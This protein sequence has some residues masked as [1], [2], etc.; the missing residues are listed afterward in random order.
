MSIK[1]LHI[2]YYDESGGAAIAVK[3]IHKALI[4]NNLN[5]KIFVAVKTSNDPNIIGPKS[6]LEEI[7]WK[8]FLSL[9]RRIQRFENKSKYDSNSYNLI[10]NNIV[11]KINNL[12]V[13]IVNLHWIGNNFIPIKDI[14]KIKKP[15]VW[16]LHD[17]WP[18]SGSEHY[19]LS[20]RYIEGYNTKNKSNSLNGIDF[21]KYC[22]QLKEKY[23][24]KMN[25]I[26]S[27][28]WQLSTAK[29]SKLFKNLNIK[30]INLPIDFNFWKPLDKSF[31][32]KELNLPLDKKVILVG[33][34]KI[35][36]KRKG[37]NFIKNIINKL[38]NKNILFVFFKKIEEKKKFEIS[39]NI[40]YFNSI[41]P[42]SY[43]LK[44]VYSA[45]DILLAPSIQES[46]GQTVLE[47]S[48]C[49][50]PSVCFENNG[51]SEIIEHKHNGYIAKENDINDFVIG[52]EWCLE[53]ITSQIMNHNP[54]KNTR[55][56]FI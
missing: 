18:Y 39:E 16:T 56:I 19:T 44:L 22:W 42:E 4:K 36:N 28:D 13:D 12:N 35:D 37:F 31:S 30:K 20:E 25:I 27:S 29:K 15:I 40:K 46:F 33:S 21:E 32:K 38:N 24:P 1:V 45:A 54:K 8:I 49:N 6:T 2:N 34:E 43:D 7:K 14:R 23:Y 9:N 51:I 55:K 53:N 48:C 41:S 17:M 52:I 50:T 3:R 5:S 26:A 47:A 11:K 10:P